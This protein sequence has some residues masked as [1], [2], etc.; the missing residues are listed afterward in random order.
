MNEEH[1]KDAESPVTLGLLLDSPF[2]VWDT[3]KCNTQ[4][5][6]A[7]RTTGELAMQANGHTNFNKKKK[8]FYSRNQSDVR[9]AEKTPS[10]KNE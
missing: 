9:P 8:M 2:S 6:S 10:D 4:G 3:E 5:E 1:M 7:Q